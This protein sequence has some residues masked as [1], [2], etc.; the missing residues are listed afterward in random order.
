MAVAVTSAILVAC[1]GQHLSAAIALDNDVDV[2]GSDTF[3]CESSVTECPV[4]VFGAPRLVRLEDL[5]R[6][7]ITVELD[8]AFIDSQPNES[9]NQIN[10][11]LQV[12]DASGRPVCA[13]DICPVGLGFGGVLS[14][15]GKTCVILHQSEQDDEACPKL[16]VVR[17]D[18]PALPGDLL[19]TVRG[20]VSTGP[21]HPG[22]EGA[23]LITLSGAGNEALI[24]RIGDDDSGKAG[25]ALDIP[26]RS[27]NLVRALNEISAAREPTRLLELDA[28]PPAH[29]EGIIGFTHAFDLPPSK[30]RVERAILRL[31]VT[32]DVTR[33]H[34]GVGTRRPASGNEGERRTYEVA[35]DLDTASIEGTGQWASGLASSGSESPP[36]VTLRPNL[37]RGRLDVIVT[38]EIAVDFSELTV[39]FDR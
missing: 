12:Y 11:S 18:P 39:I 9:I 29:V 10:L 8:Q 25:G 37:E 33:A 24:D 20:S 34:G 38:G 16:L 2:S 28:A 31:H 23:V 3:F 21:N 6:L 27:V 32:N 22:G 26:P 17:Q 4:Q 36:Q 19:L 13:G 14:N 5:D 35:I 1:F 15:I 7:F 30:A